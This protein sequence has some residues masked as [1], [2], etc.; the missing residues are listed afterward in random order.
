MAK[1][2]RGVAMQY[3]VNPNAFEIEALRTQ[4]H[5]LLARFGNLEAKP[6]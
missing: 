2:L 5:A 4:A 3:C 1:V 6:G